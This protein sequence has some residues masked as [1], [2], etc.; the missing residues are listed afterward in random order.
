MYAY[1]KNTERY[2]IHD[3]MLHLQLLG[4][5]EQAKPQIHRRRKIVKKR[6]EVNEIEAKQTMQRIND[7]VSWVFEK[8]NNIDKSL[9]NLTRRRRKKTQI[10]KV[11]DEK[12][13]L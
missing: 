8:I 3:L 11:R 2:Q 12:E 9:A 4:K 7:L 1:I 6:A 10:N 5:E 13:I